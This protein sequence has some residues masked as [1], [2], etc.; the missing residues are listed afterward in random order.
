M[1][2]IFFIVFLSGFKFCCEILLLL[3]LLLFLTLLSMIGPVNAEIRIR[4]V[5]ISGILLYLTALGE[6]SG[7][8]V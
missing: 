1:Y 2:I 5:R 3:L 6:Q 4:E 7:A 8:Y